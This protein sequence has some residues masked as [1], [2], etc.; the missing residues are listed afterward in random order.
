MT[1]ETKTELTGDIAKMIFDYSEDSDNY[2]PFSI[3]LAENFIQ[4]T[5]DAESKDECIRIAGELAKI[6]D[7]LTGVD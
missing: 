4:M 1:E 7:C 3:D 2:F 5:L 6:N